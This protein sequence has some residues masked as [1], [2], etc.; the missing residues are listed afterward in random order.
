MT[1]SKNT[2]HIPC[3]SE[4]LRRPSR[5]VVSDPPRAVGGSAAENSMAAGVRMMRRSSHAAVV[6]LP[7]PASAGAPQ[8]CRRAASGFL[9]IARNSFTRRPGAA[10]HADVAVF[11][12]RQTASG[13]RLLDEGDREEVAQQPGVTSPTICSASLQ[14]PWPACSAGDRPETRRGSVWQAAEIPAAADKDGHP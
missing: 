3:H 14:I 7:A 4:R 6:A 5:Q 8:A 11:A 10:M 9:R 2:A 1:G 12:M 13:D